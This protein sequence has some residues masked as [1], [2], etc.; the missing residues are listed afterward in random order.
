MSCGIGRRQGLD[1]TLLW[2][3]SRLTAV[4]LIQPLAWELPYAAGAALKSKTKQNKTKQKTASS[5]FE[6][7]YV[8]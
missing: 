7:S 5:E 2:L 1:A 8:R 3:W 4:A 6:D